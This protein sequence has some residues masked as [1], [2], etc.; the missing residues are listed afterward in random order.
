MTTTN[1]RQP[2][3]D[4]FDVQD[5]EGGAFWN[6]VGA[7]FEN[8]DKSHSVLIYQPGLTEQRV[9]QLRAIDRERFPVKDGKDP[10]KA[11]T[12]ELYEVVDDTEIQE[13]RWNRVGVAF[14]NKD[15]SLSL[16][17]DEGNREGKK[18]RFQLRAA[19]PKDATKPATGA[20]SVRR[21][22]A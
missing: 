21:T 5:R 15:G 11:P 19:K 18:A 6:K 1:K 7:A 20:S 17:V 3:H 2:T 8:K 13:T 16:V 14:T 9:L 4:L 10:R 22:A 12:H